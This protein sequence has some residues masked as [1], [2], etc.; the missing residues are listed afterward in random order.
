MGDAWIVEDVVSVI[1]VFVLLTTVITVGIRQYAAVKRAR[2]EAERDQDHRKLAEAALLVQENTELQ[3]REIAV[4][5]ADISTRV[6][7]LERI[8]KEV[9]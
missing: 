5:L 3:L 7:S 9:E 6:E 2:A 1:G 4:H 8:L